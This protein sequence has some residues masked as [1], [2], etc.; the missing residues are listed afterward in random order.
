MEAII[1]VIIITILICEIIKLFNGNNTST[2]TQVDHTESAINNNSSEDH[3]PHP[4]EGYVFYELVGMQYRSL[5]KEDYGIHN[6]IA[7]AETN[8]Q[9]DKNAVSVRRS[10]NGKI[11]A[12]VPKEENEYLHERITERGGTVPASFRI[13]THDGEHI[14]GCSYIKSF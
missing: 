9:Y 4:G 11:V 10:D 1:A 12:Y 5:S 7:V 14:Y 13:W 6:G 8:N 3:L 2:P